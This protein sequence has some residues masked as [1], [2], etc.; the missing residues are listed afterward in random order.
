MRWFEPFAPPPDLQAHLSCRYAATTAGR[1]DLIPDGCMDLLWIEGLGVLLC[2]PDTHA[3]SFELPPGTPVVGIRFRPGAAA[4]V[5]RV[6]ADELQDERVELVGLV[7][8]GAARTIEERIAAGHGAVGRLGVLEDL[9]RR[10]VAD[11]DPDDTVELAALVATDPAYGVEGLAATVG[12]S[13]RQLRRRFD[14]AIGYGPAFFARIARVQ[15]FAC[16]AARSPRLGIAELAAFAGY[17]DQAHVAK[18]CRAIA[19]MTPRELLAALPRTSVAVTLG[20]LRHDRCPIGTR[21][22]R[23]GGRRWMA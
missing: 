20:D 2:G 6:D 18:D 16:G 1:H 7:G 23:A 13:T 8:D 12:V 3:W 14:R 15:R 19:G 9:V 11:V 21:R 5:F 10:Q 17:A 22:R 4:G